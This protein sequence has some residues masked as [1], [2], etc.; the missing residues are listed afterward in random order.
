MIEVGD[1][2]TVTRMKHPFV[3]ASC[4]CVVIPLFCRGT[5]LANHMKCVVLKACDEEDG[6]ISF[7]MRDM[8]PE[9]IR[10]GEYLADSEV[11]ALVNRIGR[12]VGLGDI[13]CG[14]HNA[15]ANAARQVQLLHEQDHVHIARPKSS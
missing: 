11:E 1:S 13:M 3:R 4:G 7:H 12:Y 6:D 15:L 8:E 9:K 10:K 14:V 2:T 5:H